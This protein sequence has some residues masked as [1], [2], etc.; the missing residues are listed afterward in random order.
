MGCDRRE[1][2][3]HPF[4]TSLRVLVQYRS[5]S[6]L[7]RVKSRMLAANRGSRLP[8]RRLGLPVLEYRPL[9]GGTG[10]AAECCT[11]VL[12]L[13]NSNT[14]SS[15]I[16][17]VRPGRWGCP[18]K[19]SSTVLSV[20]RELVLCTGLPIPVWYFSFCLSQSWASGESSC[21]VFS[22]CH[23]LKGGILDVLASVITSIILAFTSTRASHCT[24]LVWIGCFFFLSRRRRWRE[25]C[26]TVVA[27]IW[28]KAVW[29][30]IFEHDE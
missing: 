4:R 28:W 13:E 21:C 27:F 5:S 8:L 22:P 19:Y 25:E 7:S 18:S 9:G 16:I 1:T 10:A 3:A 11:R 26:R 23:N 20:A 14:C 6:L 24:V 29:R 30:V 15:T 12:Y 17:Q 2:A